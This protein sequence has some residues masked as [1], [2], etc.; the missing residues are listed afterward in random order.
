MRMPVSRRGQSAGENFYVSLND[1]MAGILFI[2]I[3][4][5]MASA[6]QYRKREQA[7]EAASKLYE[8][9]LTQRSALI[10]DLAL[11]LQKAGHPAEAKG[12]EGVLRLG[13]A[14]LFDE[15]QSALKPRGK[16]A[17]ELL[18]Q[19][20][21]ECLP[22]GRANGRGTCPPGS[23]PILEAI[24]VEGHTD[25]VP[26]R[27][28][29]DGNWGLSSRRAIRTY[30]AITDAEEMLSGLRNARGAENLIGASAYAD[31]R[32][33]PGAENAAN[34]RVD[35]RFVIAAPTD[36][37]IEAARRAGQPPTQ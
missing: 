16:A 6:H 22:G 21:A 7:L 27:G 31:T 5:L 35:F 11:T 26:F 9:R 12:T 30:R 32:P 17:L 18:A 14:L 37:E 19:R 10:E 25:S 8:Q 34:R 20:M 24:Y 13:E 33:L 4:L 1:M 23:Q 29:P 15:G 28:D 36:A 3:L 2:F